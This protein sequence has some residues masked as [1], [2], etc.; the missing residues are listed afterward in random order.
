[1]GERYSNNGTNATSA[2]T[3]TR[4]F[5]RS[6]HFAVGLRTATVWTDP[7]K[8]EKVEARWRIAIK[9]AVVL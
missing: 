8:D 1:M 7:R 5:S 2:P 9:R 3:T 6:T 4:N